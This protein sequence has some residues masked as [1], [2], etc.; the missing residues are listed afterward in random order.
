MDIFTSWSTSN[1]DSINSYLFFIL[2]TR[3]CYSKI[4][5]NKVL[6]RIRLLQSYTYN[7]I[8]SNYCCQLNCSHLPPFDS[9]GTHKLYVYIH[10]LFASVLH[11]FCLLKL[12][13]FCSNDNTYGSYKGGAIIIHIPYI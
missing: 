13:K 10:F 8:A 3:V 6:A 12:D 4:F 1:Q 11:T 9:N 2:H 7:P 5:M